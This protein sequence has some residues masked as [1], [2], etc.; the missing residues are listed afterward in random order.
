MSRNVILEYESVLLGQKPSISKYF[1]NWSNYTNEQLALDIIRYSIK[2]YLKWNPLQVEV[3]LTNTVL[4]SL[5]LDD[6]ITYINYPPELNNTQQ[7]NYLA[8]LLYP[9]Y[10][11]FDNRNVILQTYKD[12]QDKKIKRF[13][14]SYFSGVNGS[15]RARTC[16]LYMLEQSPA[17][18]SIEEMY[19]HFAS[20]RGTNTLKAYHLLTTCIELYETPLKFLHMALPTEQKSEYFYQYYKYKNTLG[21]AIP[22]IC[23]VT[24]KA[25]KINTS[26][27]ESKASE[28]FYYYRLYRSNVKSCLFT[29][30]S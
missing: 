10:I 12:L 9:E 3:S 6:V 16:F 24:N 30:F 4:K 23:M 1:F 28:F 19:Q 11:K 13:P 14:K 29:T 20:R 26:V 25:R 5:K 18:S 8:H 22:S 27:D 7:I 2:T 15:L 17:F 21:K